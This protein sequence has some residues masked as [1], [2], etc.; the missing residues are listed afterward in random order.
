MAH[1]KGEAGCRDFKPNPILGLPSDQNQNRAPILG[2]S[3]VN[4]PSTPSCPYQTHTVPT[5]ASGSLA[6]HKVHAPWTVA[7]KFELRLWMLCSAPVT[8]NREACNAQHWATQQAGQHKP[9]PGTA[10]LQVKARQGAGSLSPRGAASTRG[11]R[12]KP[13]APRGERSRAGE[14]GGRRAAA[15]NIFHASQQHP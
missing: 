10:Q 4:S 1:G 5:G 3:K 9:S 15:P 11:A 12:A 8:G 14:G 7:S 13:A 6:S 2:F